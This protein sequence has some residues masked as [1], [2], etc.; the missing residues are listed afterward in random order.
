MGHLCPG[1]GTD[2]ILELAARLPGLDFP[3]VGGTA[4]DRAHWE[5]R[6]HRSNVYFHGHEPPARLHPYYRAFDLVLAPYQRRVACAGGIGDISRWVSPMKLFEYMSHGKAIIA[7]DLPVLREV[8]ADG[9]NSLLCPPDDVSAWA[10]A[11]ARLAADAPRRAALGAAARRQLDLQHTWL[12]RVDQV[13]P[14]LA[15]GGPRSGVRA[16]RPHPAAGLAVKGPA[17]ESPAAEGPGA[18]GE[19]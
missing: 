12:S 8:L 14:D 1:R 15:P 10:G 19:L 2:V 4:E 11:V 5:G 3:L 17:A 9:V 16:D 6:S 7:S 13:L 18:E